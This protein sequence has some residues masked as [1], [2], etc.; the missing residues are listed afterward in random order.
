[1]PRTEEQFE[2]IR[3]QKRALIMNTSLKLFAEE[4]YHNVSI[5]K[6]AE[7]AGISKGLMYNYFESKEALIISIVEGGIEELFNLFDPNHDGY[8]TD[9]EFENFVR[10]SSSLIKENTQFWKLYFALFTQP[11]VY[12]LIAEKMHD[13]LS[14]ML[15]LLSS[16]FSRRGIEDPETEA[17]LFGAM[18]DGIAYNYVMNPEMFPLENI[19]RKIINRYTQNQKK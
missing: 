6:I 5:S 7:K 3:E 4:G 1:M 16:F 17:V 19:T 14:E 10:R 15:Q 13:V 9:E 18:L 12:Q 8:I 11:K 2:E